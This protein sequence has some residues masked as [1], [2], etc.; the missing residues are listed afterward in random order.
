MHEFHVG[1]ISVPYQFG[2]WSNF[3]FWPDILLPHTKKPHVAVNRLSSTR[4]LTSYK[5]LS[6]SEASDVCTKSSIAI[7]M[8]DSNSE[9][10]LT[11]NMSTELTNLLATWMNSNYRYHETVTEC[12]WTVI[13]FA[14][15]KGDPGITLI[16]EM[17]SRG[18]IPAQDPSRWNKA[19]MIPIQ[20]F[21][22]PYHLPARE[23]FHTS[24]QGQCW[25]TC[26]YWD[27]MYTA[28]C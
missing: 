4:S 21:L 19:T 6:H 25:Y 24:L 11:S 17:K 26:Q 12:N 10:R 1:L 14:V 3:Y 13:I 5:W 22:L 9:S 16:N 20:Q 2:C 28:L 23:I 27:Y 15:W 7:K 8:W 18:K